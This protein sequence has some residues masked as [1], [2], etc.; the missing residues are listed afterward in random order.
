MKI[1]PIRRQDAPK[2]IRRQ[3]RKLAAVFGK[4]AFLSSAASGK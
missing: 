4:R 2:R 3:S 1:E